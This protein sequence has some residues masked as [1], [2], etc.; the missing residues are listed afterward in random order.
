MLFISYAHADGAEI[1]QRLQRDLVSIG[2]EVW[3]DRSRLT[4]GASWTTEIEG[5]LD[6]CE[7][8]LALLSR[9][10]FSSDICRAEQLRA[11]RHRKRVLPVLLTSDA[12]RPLYLE[13]RQFVSFATPMSYSEAFD[14]LRSQID[15]EATATIATRYVA[16]YVTAPRL[17]PRYVPRPADLHSLRQK[18]L[19]DGASGT[20]AVNALV[21]MGGIGKTTLALMLCQDR[22]IQD[23]FPDGVI[24]DHDRTRGHR[25]GSQNPRGRPGSRR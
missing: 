23:G 6:R 7:V 12:D 21:G 4:S 10:S 17:T 1:A 2:C 15:G 9:A 18:L 14:E 5:A 11:L 19:K 25:P 8:V 22:A 24:V 20:I 16:T 13:T 3:L